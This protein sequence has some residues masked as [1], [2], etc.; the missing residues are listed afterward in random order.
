MDIPLVITRAIHFAA[1]LSLF[2]FLVF[3]LLI[4]APAH[5]RGGEGLPLGL[6]RRYRAGVWLSLAL[7]SLS[8][9][10]WLFLVAREI[11]V[12][13]GR[14]L[15]TGGVVGT[16]LS[17]TQFG[18]VWIWRALLLVALWPCLA[19]PRSVSI[20][21]GLALALAT[22]LVAA[23]ALQGH[24]AAARGF[25]GMLRAG[26]DAAH[27]LAAGG[28]V[29]TLVPLA[30][31]LRQARCD[32][33]GGGSIMAA[34]ATAFSRLGLACVAVLLVTG[35]VNAW[36][37]VGSPASLVG[38]AYGRLLLV[39]LVLVA[40]MLV[41]AL[42]NYLR[43]T[44]QLA[45]AAHCNR[46]AADALARNALAEAAIGLAVIGIA[47]ALGMLAPAAHEAAS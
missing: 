45:G 10:P 12:E 17:D 23:T 9:V 28:W 19:W 7:A 15:V 21:D 41:I 4:A 14:D 31:L 13:T 47:A 8:A 16:L 26:A 20:L 29:G 34:G 42:F 2:G 1:Q 22:A 25:V 37:L 36:F 43:L 3:P 40:S 18:Q 44:P 30:L 33:E 35:V 32:G 6:Q 46:R 27:L 24:A 11:S 38:T 39:K 5:A